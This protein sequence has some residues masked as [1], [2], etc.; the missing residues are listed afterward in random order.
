VFEPRPLWKKANKEAT[1]ERA[2]EINSFPR[3]FSS[4]PDI[5]LSIDSL[6][7][8]IK[9]VIAEYV[10]MSKPAPFCVP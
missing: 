6:I 5:D 7:S 4:T 9:G 1:M 8:W 10:L 3:K 2:K